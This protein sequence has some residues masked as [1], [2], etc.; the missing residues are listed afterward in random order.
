[1][2]ERIEK[3]ISKIQTNEKEI[4]NMKEEAGIIDINRLI[5]VIKIARKVGLIYE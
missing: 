5:S 2:I 4:K 1:M 3:M